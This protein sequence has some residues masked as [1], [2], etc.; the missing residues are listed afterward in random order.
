MSSFVILSRIH[1]PS[2]FLFFVFLIFLA[3]SVSSLFCFSNLF[4]LSFFLFLAY[5]LLILPAVNNMP[6]GIIT[7]LVTDSLTSVLAATA[8]SFTFFLFAKRLDLLTLCIN[9]LRGWLWICFKTWR[10]SS[11]PLST[12]IFILLSFLTLKESVDLLCF[13]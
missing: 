5:F 13:M 7:G 2:Y 11:S 6:V 8:D 12:C 1:S 10:S 3:I 9:L 4:V